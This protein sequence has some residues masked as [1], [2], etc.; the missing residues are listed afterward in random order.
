MFLQTRF[1]TLSL[2]RPKLVLSAILMATLAQPCHAYTIL[3]WGDSLSSAYGIRADQ[4]W[5]SLLSA[6]LSYRDFRVVNE[7]IPGETSYGGI[8][9]ISEALTAHEPDLVILGLGSN[10]GLRGLD[11]G[12]M[13]DNLAHMIRKS[14]DSGAQ[15]LLLGMRIPPNYGKTYSETFHKVFTS[16][17]E[18]FK[19]PFVPFFLEPVAMNFDL[20]LEDGLH[21]NATAQ[22]I[23]LEHIW[24]AM[25]PILP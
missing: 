22:P 16:L 19:I 18:Q 3:V 20:M 7:S 17:A 21:P 24:P 1:Q 9:R 14:L 5:V 13:R 10:D 23:L 15:V 2:L 12:Q 6:R 4:G 25:I 11:T 8:E